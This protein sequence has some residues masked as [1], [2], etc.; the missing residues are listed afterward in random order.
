MEKGLFCCLCLLILLGINKLQFGHCALIDANLECTSSS[1]SC[2]GIIQIAEMGDVLTIGA[3]SC[4]TRRLKV[5]TTRGH[6]IRLEIESV[7]S[8]SQLY[9]F[10]FVY[11]DVITGFTEKSEKCNITFPTNAVEISYK[12]DMTFIIRRQV[13]NQSEQCSESDTRTCNLSHDC[14]GLLNFHDLKY[15]TYR[16]QES[17]L[18]SAAFSHPYVQHWYGEVNIRGE[19]PLCR[20][21]CVCNLHYQRLVAHCDVETKQILLLHPELVPFDFVV[22]YSSSYSSLTSFE[23]LNEVDHDPITVFNVSNR[24]LES[25]DANAFQNLSYVNRLILNENLLTHILPGTFDWIELLFLELADNMLSDLAPDIFSG[26]KFLLVLDLHGNQLTSLHPDLFKNHWILEAMDLSR[27][28]LCE[29]LPETFSP[30]TLISNLILDQNNF[31]AVQK[32]TFQDMEWLSWLFLNDNQLSSIEPG[33]FS[34]LG[35]L[36]K[37]QLSGNQLTMIESDMFIGAESLVELIISRNNISN[38]PPNVFHHIPRVRELRLDSNQFDQINLQPFTSLNHL[39]DLNI[40][41]N[42]LSFIGYGLSNQVHS[43]NASGLFPKL[44]QLLL[45]DNEIQD[46]DGNIFKEMPGINSIQIRGNPLKRVDKKTFQSLKNNTNVL[47]DEPATCCFI[48]KAHCKAQNPR[49]PYLTCLRLLPYPSVRVFMWIFGL[50]AFVGNLSILIWRCK[51]HGSE[52]IIQVSLIENLAASDFLM[53]V[54]ML[55]IASTD[56]YYQQYFPSESA[57]WRSGPLCKLAGMLSVLSSEAS[58][59]FITLISIDRFLTVRFP[60]GKYRLTKRS[61]VIALMCLWSVALLLSIIPNGISGKNSDFYDVSEVCIGLPFV[62]APVFLN[63]SVFVVDYHFERFDINSF[64]SPDTYE[65]YYEEHYSY[66]EPGNKPGLYYSIVLF[67]GINFLCFL[68]VA[69]CYVFIFVLYKQTTARTKASRKD[70][71]ITLAIR[72][73]VIVLTDFMCWAPIIV[74]GI[75]VQSATATVSPVVYV[76]IVVFILPI[77][78]A[79]NPYIYTIGKIISDYRTRTRAAERSRKVK[80]KTTALSNINEKKASNTQSTSFLDQQN[81]TETKL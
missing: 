75:L 6:Q 20:P 65:V 10:Y 8:W 32:N 74:I 56:A 53:S 79:V 9:H 57:G 11:A 23:L 16:E 44:K 58:V 50:F 64:M 54:Y 55:I 35:R 51:K 73:G 21:N 13:L 7:L 28:N 46:L 80:N 15:M 36:L 26:P 66:P 52:N 2:S 49:E 12:M 25:V 76:Y 43:S 3:L 63:R 60:T 5:N 61:A 59:F 47:V 71:K 42:H 39:L 70:Q 22:E 40:S 4:E 37:L 72:M 1:D 67:L 14:K 38:L 18:E 62:R 48:E 77:N 19:P 45:N 68:I 69:L 34:G 33:T 78:S 24:Q 30:L 29:L 41:G 31:T 27:N 17:L 81:P